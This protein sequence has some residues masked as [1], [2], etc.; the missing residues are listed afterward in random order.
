MLIEVV[1]IWEP[2]LDYRF[3]VTYVPIANRCYEDR[4]M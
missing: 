4:A 2:V 3:A 1:G